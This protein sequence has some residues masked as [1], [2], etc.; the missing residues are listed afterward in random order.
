EDRP[1][2]ALALYQ[3]LASAPADGDEDFYRAWALDGI[4]KSEASLGRDAEAAQALDQAIDVFDQAR[5]QFRSDE[6]KMGL[7]SDLQSVFER[8]IAM[9]S[10]LGQADKAFDISERSR[11]RALL[12]AVAGNASDRAGQEAAA[13]DAQS[14][15]KMLRPD[16]VVVAYHA[17]PDQLM[18]WTLSSEGVREA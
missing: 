15:E 1:E 9:H 2:E 16:E 14:L 18:A 6:F 5:S 10:K 3:Q 13:L 8:A 11:A 4:S 17:L 7:F 12:D